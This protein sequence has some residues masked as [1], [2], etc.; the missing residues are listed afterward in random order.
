MHTSHDDKRAP[1]LAT[2]EGRIRALLLPFVLL[3]EYKITAL[4]EV[5]KTFHRLGEAP[6][7]ETSIAERKRGTRVPRTMVMKVG[8]RSA[9]GV[10]PR[11]PEA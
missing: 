3:P 2:R 4:E 11:H 8:V 5:L 7:V 1:E 9:G 6:H 10:V